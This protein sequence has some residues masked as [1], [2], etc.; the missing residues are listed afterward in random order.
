MYPDY[1]GI[2]IFPRALKA[3][4]RFS[5]DDYLLISVTFEVYSLN[6]SI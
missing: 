5:L 2:L 6:F 3:G 4:L 1:I